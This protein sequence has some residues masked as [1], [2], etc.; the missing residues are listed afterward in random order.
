MRG[1]ETAEHHS[2]CDWIWLEKAD[3]CAFRCPHLQLPGFH[4]PC[5]SSYLQLLNGAV[6]LVHRHTGVAGQRLA[7]LQGAT[8]G[9]GGRGG[10]TRVRYTH[11]WGTQRYR[12]A[13]KRTRGAEQCR[14][15]TACGLNPAIARTQACV[16]QGKST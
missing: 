13:S 7:H 4:I 16:R 3:T 15:G 5:A 2:A 8:R 12:N 1:C 10:G 9:S 11:P 6:H 14:A